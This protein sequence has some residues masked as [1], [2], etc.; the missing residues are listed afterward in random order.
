MDELQR[1]QQRSDVVAMTISN[2]RSLEAGALDSDKGL[3]YATLDAIG[4]EL[5]RLGQ[6]KNL[7]DESDFPNPPEGSPARLYLLS[8]DVGGRLP[9][10][11][12]CA[13]PGGTVRPH[14]HNTWAVVAGLSGCEQNTFYR[15]IEGGHAPGPARI[16]TERKVEVRDGES[17][18]LL[19]EDV[20]SVA[21]LGGVARRH[22]HMYG[23]SLEMLSERLAFDTANERC[24]YMEINPK[25]VRPENTQ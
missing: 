1:Q 20:H 5:V 4:A 2:V 9:L 10:Y 22:F 3:T 14:N 24:D 25:I 6:H 23:L 16:E 12:T 13:L 19:P 21:T 11:L 8:E 15:R 17:V 18:S 7:F